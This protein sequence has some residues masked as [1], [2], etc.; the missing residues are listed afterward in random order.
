MP[1]IREWVLSYNILWHISTFFSLSLRLLFLDLYIHVCISALVGQ[2]LQ[3]CCCLHLQWM[4][5]I[6]GIWNVNV[7]MGFV[8][9]VCKF[10]IFCICVYYWPTPTKT[11]RHSCFL[12]LLLLLLIMCR[13]QTCNTQHATC[14]VISS[15][16][17]GF[18]HKHCIF[19]FF[20][21]SV[22]VVVVVQHLLVLCSW[23]S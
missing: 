14:F 15:N 21:V 18:Y 3:F 16:A 8:R 6:V 11:G 20:S 1:L 2:V 4:C 12:F 22:V 13:K 7:C 23:N 10:W 9:H 19:F 5:L 17:C